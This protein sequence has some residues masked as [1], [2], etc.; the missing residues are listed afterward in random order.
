M[1]VDDLLFPM[2]LVTEYLGFRDTSLICREKSGFHSLPKIKGNQCF[3]QAL[4]MTPAVS[5]GCTLGTVLGGPLRK[6]FTRHLLLD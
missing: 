1:N 3:S 6:W 4:M 2:V 5:G